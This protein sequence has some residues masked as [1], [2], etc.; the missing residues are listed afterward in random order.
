MRFAVEKPRSE[1]SE[2]SENLEAQ[3]AEEDL[4]QET[5]R[6]LEQQNQLLGKLSTMA[7]S[8]AARALF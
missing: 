5:A 2:C 1:R 4:A 6:S 8:A 7:C 3:D